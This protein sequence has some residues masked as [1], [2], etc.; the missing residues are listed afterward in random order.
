MVDGSVE[1]FSVGQ[2]SV[3]GVRWVGGGPGAL[4]GGWPVGGR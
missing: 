2:R 1:H 4:I 3:V